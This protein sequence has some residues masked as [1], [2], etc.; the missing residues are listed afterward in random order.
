MQLAGIR[1]Y[2]H[3]QEE[4]RQTR[5][6]QSAVKAMG[7]TSRTVA[8]SGSVAL[9]ASS[10]WVVQKIEHVRLAAEYSSQ[11]LFI[12]VLCGWLLWNRRGRIFASPESEPRKG[13]NFAVAA[14]AVAIAAWCCQ[15]ASSSYLFSVFSVIAAILMVVAAFVFF[16]GW[17]SLQH[18]RF[19]FFILLF[20]IPFPGSLV[21]AIISILQAQSASLS[22]MLFSVLGVPVYQQGF[23][24]TVPG[25]TIEIA[26]E[27]SGINSTI[28]LL[29]TTIII[30]E[31][32]LHTNW[33]R[34]L[35][36]LLTIPFSLVKNT[37]RIVTLTLLALHVDRSFLTGPL[38]HQGGFVFF[39]LT[40]ALMYPLL[41]V[42]QINEAHSKTRTCNPGTL[43]CF[44]G[45][46]TLP[47]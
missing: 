44:Q 27:C 12:P 45:N 42:L 4:S 38:H 10:V 43:A 16:Y 36:V 7:M 28:A 21:Q 13:A 1:R 9:I 20:A 24:L 3:L 6:A 14:I 31:D 17:R 22:A 15:L 37:V 46:S 5:S 30:S 23:F 29:L 19:P 18:A 35:F 26:R 40:L 25:V 2:H 32:A 47:Q 11:A 34:F 33:R 8:F 41:R 39:V